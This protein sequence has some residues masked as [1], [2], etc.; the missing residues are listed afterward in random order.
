MFTAAVDRQVGP[1]QTISPDAL[2]EGD[3]GWSSHISLVSPDEGTNC[4]SASSVVRFSFHEASETDH[5][6]SQ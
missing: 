5:G 6:G 2:N 1:I 3:P 4:A